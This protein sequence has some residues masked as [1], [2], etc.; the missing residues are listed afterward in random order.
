MIAEVNGTSI[1]YLQTGSGPDV[2]LLPGLGAST[3]VWYAQMRALSPVLRVTAVDLRGQGQSAKPEGPY[4][5]RLLADDVGALMGELDLPPAVVVGSSMACMV[6]VEL[7]AAYP[8]RV[9]ALV[10]A[11]GFPRLEG[12]GRERMEARAV[13]AESEGMGPLAELVPAAALGALT[14]AAQPALVGLFRALLLANDPHAYAASCRAIVGCDITPL[15]AEVRCP[16]LI[17]LG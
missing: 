2:L 11:G 15:L 14:H 10:L 16:T 8:D 13:T 4:S 5:I 9:S 6:A 7:A 1:H 17:L 12:P 3:H